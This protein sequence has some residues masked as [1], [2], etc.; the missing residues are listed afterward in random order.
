MCHY[1]HHSHGDPL[2]L[3][4]I[5]DITAHVDFTAV[6]EAA[7]D[8]GLDVLGFTS[9]AGFLIGNGLPQR[10]AQLVSED[11]ATQARLNH[12]IQM[13]TS[14]AEMGELFKVMTLGKDYDGELD[15][16]VFRDMR[17]RL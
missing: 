7:D 6:A 2:R 15:G 10:M 5:Q 8:A 12:E 3:T 16:F 9:Q 14:P 11:A 1:R 17:G 13:L 4:G